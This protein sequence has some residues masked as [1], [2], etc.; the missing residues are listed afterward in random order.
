MAAELDDARLALLVHAADAEARFL[1]PRPVHRAE[2]VAAEV[3]LRRRLNA[4]QLARAGAGNEHDAVLLAPEG[5]RQRRHD[6][7]G[8][9]GATQM[10]AKRSSSSSADGTASVEI[11]SPSA[12]AWARL[13]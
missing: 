6:E 1:E 3:V 11:H 4:V 5:A 7:Y 8:L 13:A 12:P 10:P 2:A 9:A